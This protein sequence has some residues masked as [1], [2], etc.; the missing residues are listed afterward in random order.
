LLDAGTKNNMPLWKKGMEAVACRCMKRFQPL[1]C[2]GAVSTAA[3]TWKRYINR[4]VRCMEAV[5]TAN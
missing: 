4:Y 2:M 5:S 3:S 1:S